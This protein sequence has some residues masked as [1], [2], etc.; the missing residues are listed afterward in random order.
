MPVILK[1]N[2]RFFDGTRKPGTADVVIKNG[3][4]YIHIPMSRE[5]QEPGEATCVVGC[6]FGI[7]FMVVTYD[8]GGR[9]NF[10]HGRGVK[11]KKWRYFHRRLAL[12]ER[13]TPYAQK[14]LKEIGSKEHRYMQDVN[15]QLSKAIVESHPPGT[16]FV[17]EDM[18]I[19]PKG[20]RKYYVCDSWPFHDLRS[21]IEY[22]AALRGSRV[23]LID[24]RY[25]SQTCPVCG[26]RN[27]SNRDRKRHL[28]CCGQCGYTTNDDR[29][30][31]MN[32]YQRGVNSLSGKA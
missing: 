17:L 31:A 21:K 3:K 1:G 13:N 27:R 6:D 10:Y 4:W 12:E 2:E 8:S 32:I 11:Q 20:G 9:T 5:K 30:A 22:K 14:R 25:T 23:V 16:V 28:F 24:P 18:D 26:Y 15:H 29:A 7:N 19:K